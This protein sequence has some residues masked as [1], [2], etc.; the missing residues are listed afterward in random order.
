MLGK[1]LPELALHDPWLVLVG[2][3]EGRAGRLRPGALS[4]HHVVVGVRVER[5]I[6]VD[7]IDRRILNGIVKLRLTA[8]SD[9]QRGGFTVGSSPVS[10]GS[11]D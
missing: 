5:R 6:E 4:E 2:A 9:P 7:E 10:W 3:G 1:V 8:V 11:I